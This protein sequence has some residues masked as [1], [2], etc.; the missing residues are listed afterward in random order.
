MRRWDV[1]AA[2][3]GGALPWVS[4]EDTEPIPLEVVIL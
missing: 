4:W 1:G 3:Y 2:L